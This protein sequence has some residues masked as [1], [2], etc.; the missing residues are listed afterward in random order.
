MAP[1][2]FIPVP[3]V[4]E[5]ELR[6]QLGSVVMVNRLFYS[7]NPLF[8]LPSTQLGFTGAV[9][10]TVINEY[11]P[12]I[13]QNVAFNRVRTRTMNTSSDPWVTIDYVD[14]FGTWPSD[15]LS[16]NVTCFARMASGHRAG[17]KVGATCVPAPPR[18]AVVENEFTDE[19]ISQVKASM[20]ELQEPIF[21]IGYEMG[22]VS[23][24]EGGAWRAEGLF[25]QAGVCTPNRVVSP[26]RRRLRNDTVLP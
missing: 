25:R 17:I 16:A 11:L 19:Y 24:R 9:G 8:I 3:D 12:A 22:W 7:I 15:A 26:R 23:F 18:D 2:P 20:G 4:Y 21:T 1:R 5:A 6:F 10:T 13:A 14:Y